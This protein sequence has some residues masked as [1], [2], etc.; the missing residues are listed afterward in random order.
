MPFFVRL[1]ALVVPLKTIP[2]FRLQWSKSYRLF[3]SWCVFF[4]HYQH[5]DFL[6]RK[7]L[8]FSSFCLWNGKIWNDLYAVNFC[9]AGPSYFN[10]VSGRLQNFSFVDPTLAERRSFKRKLFNLLRVQV[11]LSQVYHPFASHFSWWTSM[12]IIP[13]LE[14]L[15]V[16]RLFC[17]FNI[18]T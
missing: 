17:V 12:L 7:D 13:P 4:C 5:V 10:Y 6:C 14:I 1:Y 2:D 9:H 3:G 15:T 8:K 16:W 11:C 18:Q